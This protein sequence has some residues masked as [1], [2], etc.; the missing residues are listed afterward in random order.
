M[1]VYAPDSAVT[2]GETLL[3]LIEATY[4]AFRDRQKTMQRNATCP[5]AACQAIPTL[6]LKFITHSGEY[7]LQGVAGTYKPLGSCVNL[8]HRLLKNR[9]RESTGWRGYALFSEQSLRHL[10]VWPE[11]IH[12]EVEEFEHL[13]EVRTC[14]INLDRQYQKRME[15]RRVLLSPEA[16]DITISYVFAAPPPVVWECER[17][18]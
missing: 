12:P 3:E 16:A 1:F 15:E 9:V 11:G 6:D 10:G 13:G 7:V 17:S 8:A 5:C 14:S 2:R 4:V 18:S